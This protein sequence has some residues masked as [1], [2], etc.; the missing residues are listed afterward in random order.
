M[1][2]HLEKKGGFIMNILSRPHYYFPQPASVLRY[3][4]R[5]KNLTL[6]IG[7][8]YKVKLVFFKNQAYNK[9]VLLMNYHLCGWSRLKPSGF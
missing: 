4:N 2:N 3:Q 9:T 6:K 1:G 5:M 7:Q 8:K